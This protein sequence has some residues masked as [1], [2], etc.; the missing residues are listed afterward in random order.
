MFRER[1]PLRHGLSEFGDTAAK[2][3]LLGLMMGFN[4]LIRPPF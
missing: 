1:D 2:V 3:I 4:Q